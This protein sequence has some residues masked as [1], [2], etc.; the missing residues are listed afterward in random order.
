MLD[1]V[2]KPQRTKR[3]LLIIKKIL[4]DVLNMHII[5]ILVKEQLITYNLYK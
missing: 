1:N 4:K 5:N 3:T 2:S